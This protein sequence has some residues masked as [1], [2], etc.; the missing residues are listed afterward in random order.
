VGKF[1]SDDDDDDDDDD[2]ATMQMFGLTYLSY[3][4]EETGLQF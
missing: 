1:D 4:L 3:D 2:K